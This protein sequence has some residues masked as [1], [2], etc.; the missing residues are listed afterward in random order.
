MVQKRG[1]TKKTWLFV[2]QDPTMVG[3][4][5]WNGVVFSQDGGMATA[6]PGGPMVLEL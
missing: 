3:M 2:L 1:K 4:V 6:Q 5:G